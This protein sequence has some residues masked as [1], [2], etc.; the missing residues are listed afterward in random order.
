M[1]AVTVTL[2]LTAKNS[3]VFL[4]HLSRVLPE[5]RNHT[6]C[7]YV[8][9]LV[10]VDRPQEFVLIQGW[11]SREDQQRYL[12]WR[13]TTGALAEFRSMLAEDPIVEYWQPR[14]A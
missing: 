2:R 5:T 7:R 1:M 10:Q 8:N 12:Q 9:T 11:D 6:G 14:D 3:E 13:Q 4:Q